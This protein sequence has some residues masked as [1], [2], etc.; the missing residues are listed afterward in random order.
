MLGHEITF[1]YCRTPGGNIP[2]RKIFDCWWETFPVSEFMKQYYDAAT[3]EKIV[4][5]PQPKA[6]SLLDLIAQAQQR[7]DQDDSE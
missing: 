2:C 3:L 7:C 4:A 6:A 1:A 5:P